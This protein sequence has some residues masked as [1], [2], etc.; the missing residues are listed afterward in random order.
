MGVMRDP[1]EF[2]AEGD[3]DLPVVH[4]CPT[5]LCYEHHVNPRD[6]GGGRC[7]FIEYCAECLAQ[8][9]RFGDHPTTED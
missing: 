2:H 7:W 8:I 9:T 4:T 3:L 1:I 6:P 5:G